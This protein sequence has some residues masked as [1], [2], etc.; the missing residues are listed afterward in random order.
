M[1]SPITLTKRPATPHLYEGGG[2]FGSL[3]TDYFVK[4]KNLKK[5]PSP[6]KLSPKTSK[7]L[8]RVRKMNST[9]TPTTIPTEVSDINI[10]WACLLVNQHR[11][12][13][14][15]TP[16]NQDNKIVKFEVLLDDCMKSSGDLSSTC[17]I[18]VVVDIDGKEVQYIFIAKLLP[19]DDPCR[20]YV[21]EA[22]VFEKEI[23]IYFE[24]LPYIRNFLVK[25]PDL[26]ML[27]FDSVPTCIYGSNDGNG[28]GVLV[29]ECAQEK[30]YLH[31]VDPEGL[32]LAQVQCTVKF[33]AKFHAIGSA[34]LIKKGKDL[35]LRYPFLT[36]KVDSTSIQIQGATNMFDVC[37]QFI[38]SVPGHSA[39]HQRF[40]ALKG[41][42]AARTMFQ[43]MRRQHTSPLNTII[44]GELWEKNLL[45]RHSASGQDEDLACVVLDWKNAKIA[46][47]T[48]DLAFLVLSSTNNL[49]RTESLSDILHVYYSTFCT[50]L[51]QLGVELGTITFEDFYGDYKMSMK[52]AFLQSVC[53]LVQEMQY[54]EQQLNKG[55]GRSKMGVSPGRRGISP[56]RAGVSQHYDHGEMLR[57]FEERTLTLMNDA[58]SL[59][60]L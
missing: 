23:S 40:A 34:L 41:T 18:I 57:A 25:H 9:S 12:K 56:G 21:F 43:C 48:K 31:P 27:M 8:Q 22:N 20:I 5:S 19:P 33:M 47:A 26:E 16:I 1:S 36:T 45:Y 52:G 17:R 29:F 44:H 54:L 37:S 39:L 51:A 11:L 30:G 14:G 59:E 15:Q 2:E 42:D 58:V 50:T 6:P 53:V 60:I 28:A 38:A 7:K 10:D 4:Q 49:L 3:G 35:R 46:S 13:Y 24:L 55:C 32:S